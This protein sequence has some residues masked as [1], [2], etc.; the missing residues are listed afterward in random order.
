MSNTRPRKQVEA[1]LVRKGFKKIDGDH[2]RFIY[3]TSDSDKKTSINTKVSHGS[4]HSEI[5]RD[6]LKKMSKQCQLTIDKFLSLID[7]PLSR[8]EYEHFL[9]ENG[10][11]KK[12]SAIS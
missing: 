1:S 3:Y 4:G 11:I 6:N 10:Y 2:I 7:C 8:E 12:D 9:L 5:S